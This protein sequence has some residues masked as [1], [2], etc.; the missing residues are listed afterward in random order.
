MLGSLLHEGT[1]GMGGQKKSESK[2]I[3]MGMIMMAADLGQS[4]AIGYLESEAERG[5][6]SA[7]DYLKD[8]K[9]SKRTRADS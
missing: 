2:D 3:G 1:I 5:N 7:R 8:A 9:K 6:E 4:D